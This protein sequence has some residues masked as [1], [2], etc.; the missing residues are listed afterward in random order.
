MQINNALYN[1]REKLL[2]L[3]QGDFVREKKLADQ[4][5]KP[6]QDLIDMYSV[7]L[8]NQDSRLLSFIYQKYKPTFRKLDLT[9]LSDE[10]PASINIINHLM[11]AEELNETAARVKSHCEIIIHQLQLHYVWLN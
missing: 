10:I 4:Y 6:F 7:S 2:E 8:I 5:F 9:E 11:T 3:S 1:I